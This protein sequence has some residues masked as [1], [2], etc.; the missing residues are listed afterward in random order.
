PCGTPVPPTR[1]TQYQ[2]AV[3]A[4]FLCLDPRQSSLVPTL[5]RQTE[6]TGRNLVI[7]EDVVR[8]LIHGT[9]E[10]YS[11]FLPTGRPGDR[12]ATTSERMG[13]YGEEAPKLA[14]EAC[15]RALA[16]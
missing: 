2:G 12:G 9:R 14:L 6:I 13:V 3:V 7:G 10:T 4:R 1:C 16:D 11:V 5:Y 8:D 15:G